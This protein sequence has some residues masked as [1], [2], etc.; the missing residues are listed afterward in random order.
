MSEDEWI[1]TILIAD[2]KVS[3]ATKDL[4]AAVAHSL[5]ARKRAG[6]GSR[7]VSCCL[8]DIKINYQRQNTTPNGVI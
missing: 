4:E 2:S 6:C 5:V 3:W 1:N 7:G 8:P